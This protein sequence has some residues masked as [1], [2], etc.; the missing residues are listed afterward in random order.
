MKIAILNTSIVTADGNYTVKT[1]TPDAAI[2]L[3]RDADID[4]AV[5]HDSTAAILSTI[6]G[7]TVPVS[8]QLFVQ[9]VGQQAIVFKLNGRPEPGRELSRSEL[10]QIGFTFKLITRTA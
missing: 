10:E 4:S 3:V 7:V 9:Q 5:G 8:R 1:I 6:L 2:A